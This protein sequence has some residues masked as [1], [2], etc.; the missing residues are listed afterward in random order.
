MIISHKYKFIFI[1]TAKTAGTSTE[2]ALSKHLGDHDIITPISPEDETIRQQIGYLGPQNCWLP[3]YRYKPRQIVRRALR[4][5]KVLEYFN[6]ISAAK[7]RKLVGKTVW[8]SYYKF[9]FSRDPWDRAISLYYWRYKSEPRPSFSE[10]AESED[11]KILVK[12]GWDL[13]T[14]DGNVIVDRVCAYENLVNELESTRKTIGI[15]EPLE[16]PN[17]K[18]KYRDQQKL[19]PAKLSKKDKDKIQTVANKEL[20]FMDYKPPA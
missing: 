20:L 9:C 10:F 15:P 19:K 18:S 12:K 14:I 2:I 8:D 11:L 1:K 6:H 5:E 4:K 16:L 3:I 17:A 7:I 13:F